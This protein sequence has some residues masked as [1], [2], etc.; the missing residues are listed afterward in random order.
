MAIIKM[1]FNYGKIFILGLGSFGLSA[2]WVIYNSF[3]PLFLQGRFHMTPPGIGFFMTIDNIAALLI[4]PLIGSWSDR[5]RTPIG[6]RMPFIVTGIPAAAAAFVLVPGATVLP[7][8]AACTVTLIFSMT[9]WRTPVIALLADITPSA[10]RSRANGILN[11]MG[12]IG[13]ITAAVGGG[14]LFAINESYPFRMGAGLLLF[15]GIMLFIFIS[16]PGEYKNINKKERPL[17]RES[18]KIIFFSRE[19][20]ALL[21]F[22]SHF[23]WIMALSS[24]EAFFTLYSLNHLGYSGAY[25]SRILGLF[26]LM[27]LISAVPAGVLGGIF[28]RKRTIMSGL[29]LIFGALLA[30]YFLDRTILTLVPVR[31]PLY[32]GVP[33][34]GGLLMVCGTAWMMINVN[35]LPMVLD[36]TDGVRAGTYTGICFFFVTAA[37]IAGPNVNGW[38][39]QIS[40][41]NYSSIYLVSSFFIFIAF[42]LMSGVKRGESPSK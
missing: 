3:V 36:M 39:I 28:G 16:E 12:G 22:L 11:F 4:L 15:S 31:L 14:A 18:M 2:V 23:F 8:F 30:V 40:N 34:I 6:R 7:I 33:L 19:R 41:N 29:I 13:G 21:L 38:V 35:S 24:I 20:S 9:I 10:Y 25:S 17:L 1:K 26:P 5:V 27:L 42:F 37:A 32:G